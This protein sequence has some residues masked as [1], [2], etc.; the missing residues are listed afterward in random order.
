MLSTVGTDGVVTARDIIE[1]I[2][3]YSVLVSDAGVS[4]ARL[5]SDLVCPAVFIFN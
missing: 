1:G 4:W 5:G 3:G 2:E